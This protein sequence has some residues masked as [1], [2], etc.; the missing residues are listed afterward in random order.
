MV[1]AVQHAQNI[2][3]MVTGYTTPQPGQPVEGKGFYLDSYETPMGDVLDIFCAGMDKWRSSYALPRYETPMEIG[4]HISGKGIYAGKWTP[5]DREETS[6]GAVFNLFA[7]P[8]RLLHK[9]GYHFS[10]HYN[11]CAKNVKKLKNWHGH[12]GSNLKTDADIYKAIDLGKFSELEKWFIP[13]YDILENNLEANREKGAL[14]PIFTHLCF[15]VGETYRYGSSTL[16]D[17]S[18]Q[19]LYRN[20]PMYW[21]EDDGSAGREFAARHPKGHADMKMGGAGL[22]IHPVRAELCGWN[23]GLTLE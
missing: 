9:K 21:R 7:A 14:K 11:K 5:K 4:Q 22:H 17:K 13:T 1:N 23:I 19:V 20:F 6:L 12:D 10:D 8:E 16:S 2:K 18:D 3:N 15:Q